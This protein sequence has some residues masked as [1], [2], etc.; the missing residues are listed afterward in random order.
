MTMHRTSLALAAAG[1]T[2]G[3]AAVPAAA[4]TSPE[5]YARLDS[6]GF[7]IIVKLTVQPGQRERFLDIMKA[8]VEQART[9][10]G[11]V[12]FRILATPDPQVFMGYES[13]ADRAAFDEFAATPASAEFMAAMKPI[14]VGNVEVTLL[15]R[16]P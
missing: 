11:V 13:F 6:G 10:P 7:A 2:A 14:L 1:L 5:T 8:R 12:D 16:L 4:Q 15:S 9:H 3:L